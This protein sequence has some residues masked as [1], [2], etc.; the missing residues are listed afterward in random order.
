M[1]CLL[2]ALF[3]LGGSAL[4]AISFQTSLNQEERSARE[5][6][7]MVLA[8]L[9]MADTV[10]QW[11]DGKSAAD[12]LRK[13]NSQETYSAIQLS[14][15]DGILYSEGSAATHFQNLSNRTDTDHLVTAY[16]NSGGKTPYLQVSSSLHIGG[17]MLYLNLGYDL[18]ELYEA[19]ALQW[20][21][22]DWIFGT[23]LLVCTITA[24]SVSRLLTRPLA[25]LSRASREIA[26]GNLSCRSNILSGDEI[27]SLSSDF[28]AMAQQVEKSVQDLK[29]AAERQEQFMGSFA[30]ELKTPMT[31]IIGYADLLRGQS[32]TSE[33]QTDAAN[34]IFSEGRRLENLSFKLLDIFVADRELAL[35]PISPSCIV[36]NIAEHLQPIY[37]KN[38]M[39][40]SCNCEEG[41]CFL[42]PD[43]LRTLLLNLLDNAKKALEHGGHIQ[44][45]VVMQP[46]GCRLTVADNGKGIPPA[47][48]QHLTEAFYRVD[49]ARSRAQG[50]AGLG[51]TLCAKIVELHHG[52]LRFNSRPGKG[53]TVTA[54]LKGGRP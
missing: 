7:R 51:L 18:S 45:A 26:S 6:C 33:E 40:I 3:S 5:S 8:T 10:D 47:A 9:Q 11:I 44:I 46:D 34:Y 38:G 53:T 54:E 15:S 1:I 12:T 36:R 29:D 37:Q 42:E 2:S 41:V 50:S 32:L 52:T 20:R 23:M 13:L 19:R 27:A 16:F 30:H 21:T 35:K 49:K 39:T 31:S 48:L 14:S 43:L 25:R 22:Y 17:K 24:Y 28:D 4:I